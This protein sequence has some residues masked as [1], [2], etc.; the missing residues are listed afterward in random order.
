MT[1]MKILIISLFLTFGFHCVNG[2]LYI[3]GDALNKFTLNLND[4]LSNSQ[5]EFDIDC[6]NL[7]DLKFNS[8]IGGSYPN[9]WSR[10]SFTLDSNTKVANNL[11]WP[12]VTRYEIGDTVILD[13]NIWT[14]NLDYIYGI[15]GAGNYGWPS[16]DTDFIIFRKIKSIDTTYAFIEISSLYYSMKFHR[17]ISTCNSPSIVTTNKDLMKPNIE[18]Y[19]NPFSNTIKS[20]IPVSQLKIYTLMGELLKIGYTDSIETNE[21]PNGIYIIIVITKKGE[22]LRF[23]MEKQ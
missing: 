11:V 14:H 19:P 2:Q 17:I 12:M 21:L 16:I 7:T 13:S 10:L 18:L 23:K 5:I 20:K 15:G 9:D 3:I 8:H 22:M 1:I 6:D 4:T